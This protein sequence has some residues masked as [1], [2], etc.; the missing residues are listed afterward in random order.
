MTDDE[1]TVL[2]R[3]AYGRDAD[4]HLDP[5]SLARL[6]EL[7]TPRRVPQTPSAESVE[8]TEVAQ[9]EVEAE[10]EPEPEV[11]APRPTPRLWIWLRGLRRSTVL[12]ALGVLAVG[13]TLLT[14]LT[15]VQRV[16]PDPLQV[17]ATQIARLDTDTFTVVPDFFA[18]AVD[19]NGDP[20]E[21]QAYDQFF[22]MRPVV[23]P[24]SFFMPA[25]SES[26]C[27][28][29]YP[30]ANVKP[31]SSSFEGPILSGCAAGAFPA[32]V[33]FTTDQDGLPPELADAFPD[34]TALQFVY[35]AEHHE[36]VVFTDRTE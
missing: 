13:A 19:A 31:G 36:V 3:R 1:L 27:L 29:L 26:G 30:E 22:G 25:A 12:I 6:R 16:Q 5:E 14:V 11:F 7:E 21:M 34:A 28:M 8:T 9:P 17:G 15:L 32:M 33:Q 18:G 2:R 4:I 35:D 20:L 10:A 24:W 23:S